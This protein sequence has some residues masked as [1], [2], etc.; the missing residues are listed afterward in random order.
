MDSNTSGLIHVVNK[1][2]SAGLSEAIYSILKLYEDAAICYFF[3]ADITIGWRSPVPKHLHRT[4]VVNIMKSEWF[5]QGRTWQELIV[6]IEVR[7]FRAY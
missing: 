6:P 2:S 5:A 3:L 4:D 7:F 1:D